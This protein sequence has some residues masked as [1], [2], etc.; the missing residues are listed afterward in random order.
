[1]VLMDVDKERLDMMYNLA[2]RY[3][4]ETNAKILIRKTTDRRQSLEDAYF[5]INTVKI[6]GYRPMVEERRIAE[7][8]GYYRGIGER[9][10]DYYGRIGAYH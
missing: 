6:G 5:V 2:T 1:M 8:H 7:K 3:V 10:S 9:V 4:N